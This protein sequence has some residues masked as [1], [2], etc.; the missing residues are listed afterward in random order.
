[1]RHDGCEED[2]PSAPAFPLLRRDMFFLDILS[3]LLRVGAAVEDE[4]E[5]DVCSS[6]VDDGQPVFMCTGACTSALVIY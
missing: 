6:V 3:L 2:A 5:G 4:E 1:M